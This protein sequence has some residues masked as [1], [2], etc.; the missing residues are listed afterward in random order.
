MSMIDT[1]IGPDAADQDAGALVAAE[2]ELPRFVTPIVPQATIAARALTAV[3][4]IMT[5]LAVITIG[6]V[7]LL[8]SAAGDW[9]ADLAREVTIQVR[10]VSGRDIEADV[11]KAAAIA[12]AIPGIAGV[13]P[14]SKQESSQ[15]LQPWLDGLALDELPVPRIVAV[16]IT[17]G[18]SP[19]L[20]KLRAALAAQLPPASLD[21]HREFVDH[22][23][24]ATSM[25]VVAASAVLLMVMV[26]TVL[27]VTFATRAAM[28]TNRQVIEV[29]HFIGARNDFIAG[30]F[31][32]HFLWLGLKGGAIG[33]G[34]ALLLF[35]VFDLA[36]GWIS[37]QAAGAQLTAMFG[38][39]SVG[40]GGYI[41]MLAQMALTALLTAATAR[42]TVN[43]TLDM[44][45]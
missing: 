41:A 13:R 35:A 33:G 11:A 28:A 22:M 39:F 1:G 26:A 43:R 37:A 15:L 30:H 29:L 9:Q 10:P 23:R 25:M 14:Y 18:Q 20:A 17:P 6:A 42:Q 12:G 36:N 45:Q 34:L 31:Q 32:R 38:S 27:S 3:I 16:A 40:F 4:A 8:R 21:D 19:D 44:V 24:S 2:A 7:M 5:F